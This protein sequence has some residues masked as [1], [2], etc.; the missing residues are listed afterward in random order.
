MPVA[1]DEQHPNRRR[2]RKARM[3]DHFSADAVLFDSDGVL[4]DSK[5]AGERAWVD[6][7]HRYGL[8][9]SV[10]LTGLHGRRSRET[11]ALYVAPELAEAATAVID[12]LELDSADETRGLP[13]A[14]ALVASIP[15]ARR[16]V[17]TSAPRALGVARLG[18][19]GVPVPGVLITSEAVERG[20]PAPDPYL[21]AA[22]ALGVP[23]GR[24]LV[25]E[26]SEHGIGAA[27]AAGAGVVVGV[28]ASALGLGCDAVVPD[29]AAARWVGDG[30]EVSQRLSG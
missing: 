17:V 12:G 11:V 10:V 15:D 1:C 4:V 5:E 3:T 19:A 14:A 28:G 30:I 29:L 22:A 24:C 9:P 13:G 2:D 25:F 20:K 21:A 7:S 8:D 16:A 23:I 27:R 26:D 6:W 18:A